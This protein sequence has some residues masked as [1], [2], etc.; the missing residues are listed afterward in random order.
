[1]SPQ[2]QMVTAFTQSLLHCVAASEAVNAGDIDEADRL[3]DLSNEQSNVAFDLAMEHGWNWE[4][5]DDWNP[6]GEHMNH[7]QI[8]LMGLTH[9]L[10]KCTF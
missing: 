5:D 2:I 1:M 6:V 7:E 4:E 10:E 9:A 3:M 8:A